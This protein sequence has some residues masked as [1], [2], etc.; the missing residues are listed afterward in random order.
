[1][2]IFGPETSKTSKLLPTDICITNFWRLVFLWCKV[3][4]CDSFQKNYLDDSCF[5]FT[6]RFDDQKRN[7]TFTYKIM[8]SSPV[9]PSEYFY[10]IVSGEFECTKTSLRAGVSNLSA[11]LDHTGRRRVILGHTWTTQMLMETDEQIKVLSK[12]MILCWAAFIA[13]LGCMRPCGLWVG[14]P[15]KTGGTLS[16][17][18]QLIMS[19][20]SLFQFASLDIFFF[21]SEN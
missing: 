4:N 16:I 7:I 2:L 6:P 15:R 17:A 5:H 19:E 10:C 20:T 8:L 21:Y 12:F 9:L 1:M 3:I 11:S 13:I 18:S 14:H